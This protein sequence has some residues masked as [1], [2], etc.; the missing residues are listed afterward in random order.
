MNISGLICFFRVCN[1]VVLDIFMWNLIKEQYRFYHFLNFLFFNE[2]NIRF[3]WNFGEENGLYGCS[4]CH[5]KKDFV[6][7]YITDNPPRIS[8]QRQLDYCKLNLVCVYA[9]T[10]HRQNF[11]K[12]FKQKSSRFHPV[13]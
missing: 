11:D 9:H 8:L 4:Y 13:A 2:D 10:I 5:A 7:V 6:V 12:D 3:Y 1:G